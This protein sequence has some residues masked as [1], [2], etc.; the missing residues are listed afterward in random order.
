MQVVCVMHGQKWLNIHHLEKYVKEGFKTD[1]VKISGKVCCEGF[2]LTL[3]M[4]K[5]IVFVLYVHIL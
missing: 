3:N 5:N 2:Q 4:C 1:G